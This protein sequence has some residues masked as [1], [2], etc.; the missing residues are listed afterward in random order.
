MKHEYWFKVGRVTTRIEQQLNKSL[1]LG[2]GKGP[3]Q[4]KFV[5]L[6]EACLWSYWL[7]PGLS[8]RRA[9]LLRVLK[10]TK[11]T[12]SFDKRLLNGRRKQDK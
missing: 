4:L 5:F 2:S 6:R 7:L 8:L 3:L 11:T 10:G 9:K 1:V 12:A